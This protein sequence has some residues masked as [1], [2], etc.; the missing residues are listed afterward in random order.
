[1]QLVGIDQVRKHRG[2][3]LLLGIVLIVIGSTAIGEAVLLTAFSMKFLGWLMVFAGV[4]GVV[5]AFSFGRGWGGFFIDLIT[6]VVYAVAG[7][8]I[9]AN[10]AASAKALTLMIAMVLIFEGMFRAIS[11]IIARYPHW[12]WVLFNGVV[13]AFLGLLIWRQWPYSGLWVIGLYVGI[14][15]I[16]NGWSLVML[17]VA[18]KH[19]PAAGEPRA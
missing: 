4:A 19:A 11:A 13:T 1:M 10:P 9:L 15:M 2:W 17:S 16:L 14:S 8:M 6:G 5:H 3:F 18:V 7:F 12:G